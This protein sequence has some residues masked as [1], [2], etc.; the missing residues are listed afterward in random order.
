MLTSLLLLSGTA[1]LRQGSGP[2][3]LLTVPSGTAG[4][5]PRGPWAVQPRGG[6][7]AGPGRSRELAEV[8]GGSRRSLET[9]GETEGG[10]LLLWNN[11]DGKKN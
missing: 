11:T 10:V 4:V 6:Q 3:S 7:R 9:G 1:K 8:L 2:A 5:T